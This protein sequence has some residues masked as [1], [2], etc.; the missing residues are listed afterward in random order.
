ML[1]V[2]PRFLARV[3]ASS[4]SPAQ[5][6]SEHYVFQSASAQGGSDVAGLAGGGDLRH[7]WVFKTS[8]LGAKDGIVPPARRQ[9]STDF[10]D[11]PPA[12]HPPPHVA[13]AQSYLPWSWA[14]LY[15]PFASLPLRSSA[16]IARLYIL[17]GMTAL[18]LIAMWWSC[19]LSPTTKTKGYGANYQRSGL[20]ALAQVPIAV[21]LGVR[22]NLPGLLLGMGYE[23]L[24]LFHKFIGRSLFICASLH[25]V[26][27]SKSA[28]QKRYLA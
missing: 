22:G 28:S 10:A 26:L 14:L 16:T 8:E 25:V 13:P 11:L 15:T 18:V 27:C 24:K 4:P 17:S 12:F 6:R 20:V 19:D 21:A 5:K 9:N 23:R 7:G 1:L 3:F 2:H